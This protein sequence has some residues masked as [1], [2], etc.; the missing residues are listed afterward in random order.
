[1]KSGIKII[2]GPSE[3]NPFVIL[4]KPSGLPSAPLK[5]SDDCALN[6]CLELFPELNEVKGQK[7]IEKGLL[8]R[9]DTET[10]GL[11]LIASTQASYDFLSEQQKKGNLTK[12][13]TAYCRKAVN[14]PEG[15]DLIAAPEKKHI[16]S[17]L[18]EKGSAGTSVSSF[19]RTWGKG[20]REVR[21]VFQWSNTAS[22][23]KSTGTLY[24]TNIELYREGEGYKAV[25][26]LTR[27]FRHQVRTHLCA[28]GYPIK[29]DRLYDC[30]SGNGDSFD[31]EASSLTFIHPVTG[32]EVTFK[33][34]SADQE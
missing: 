25:C 14:L 2:Q 26:S 28:C 17:L 4:Y 5:D 32:K 22:I 6:R 15:M 34:Q 9:I 21:P 27:G 12:T 30:S 31:F 3:E 1:M 18:S 29:G 23:K 11:L 16:D 10:R 24:T 20:A 7:E 33:S 8:H 19:F 13:Y